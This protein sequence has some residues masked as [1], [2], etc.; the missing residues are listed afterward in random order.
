[1][2]VARSEYADLS[3]V[4]YCDGKTQV[5]IGWRRIDVSEDEIFPVAYGFILYLGS[6]DNG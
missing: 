5:S 6:E 4:I 2:A 3:S 1:M